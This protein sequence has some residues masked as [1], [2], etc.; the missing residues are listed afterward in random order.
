MRTLVNIRVLNSKGEIIRDIE[1]LI[2]A[3]VKIY[4]LRESKLSLRLGTSARI[5]FRE[6]AGRCFGLKLLFLERC[7]YYCV[8][9]KNKYY[10]H[11]P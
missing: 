9:T 7:F 4:N 6:R 10:N 11:V 2:L 8:L 5:Y 3:G 1:F